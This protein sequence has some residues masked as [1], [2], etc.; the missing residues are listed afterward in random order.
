MIEMETTGSSPTAGQLNRLLIT[1][2]GDLFLRVVRGYLEK[3]VDLQELALTF[4]NVHV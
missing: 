2:E 1:Q 3:I 4:T